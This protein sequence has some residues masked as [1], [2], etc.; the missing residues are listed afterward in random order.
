MKIVGGTERLKMLHIRR[1]L[2]WKMD[3][4][5]AGRTVGAEKS[6]GCR[7]VQPCGLHVCACGV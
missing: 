5:D 1:K 4:M 7:G 2:L 3:E 6:V